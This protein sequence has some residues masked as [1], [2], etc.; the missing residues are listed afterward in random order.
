M[1]EL[2]ELLE[3]LAGADAATR[4]K[5]FTEAAADYQDAVTE[6]SRRRLEALQ[7]LV[8]EG[9]THQE[10]AAILG[11]SRARV[12]KLL[13]TG[14]K[15]ERALL[16]TGALTIAVGGKSEG[17][18]PNPSTVFS[19]ES[20]QARDL[21]TETARTYGLDVTHDMV[22]PPGMVNLIR[23]NLVVIGSPRLLPFVAQ[24]LESDRNLGF[25]NGAQGWYLTEGD[26]L[27]RSPADR[28][29]SAD[30]A[31]LGR[32]PRPDSNGTFLYVAGIHAM[33][34]LGAAT[35]LCGHVAELYEQVRTRRW[36]MLI[37]CRYDPD[38]RAVL[39]TEPITPIYQ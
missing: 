25:G 17:L 13:T 36:S 16:G 34:T 35:H 8:T 30:V 9:K 22:D 26:K 20:L 28:G 7:E 15:P 23:P 21:I 39:S 14:P 32:L 37:E 18:R 12:G 3:E 19:A 5:R 29:D 11:V 33:G 6:V 24:V 31:Y 4:A 10:I 38:T 2:D 27:H 1:R